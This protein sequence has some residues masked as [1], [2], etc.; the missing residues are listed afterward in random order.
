MDLLS[1][2]VALSRMQFALTATFHM[3][4]PVLTTGMGIYLVIV[5]GL[6][7]KTRNSDYYYH[8][9]FWAKLYVLNFGIGVATGLPMEFQF[10]TNWAPFS[11]AVG[12]F[13]GVF[14]ASRLQWHLCWKLDSWVSCCLAGNG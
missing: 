7:L 13:L 5:E 11:E 6:W 8:A 12:D 4:W 10:G 9:R 2:T 1:N 14:W 3:L